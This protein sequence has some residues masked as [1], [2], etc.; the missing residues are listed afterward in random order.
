LEPVKIK[1]SDDGKIIAEQIGNSIY[2]RFYNITGWDSD[3]TRRYMD[4]TSIMSADEFAG[5]CKRIVNAGRD[6]SVFMQ[7]PNIESW[8]YDGILF[9]RELS[10][11]WDPHPR[12][13]ITIN[14][15]TFVCYPGGG[16]GLDI[17]RYRLDIWNFHVPNYREGH[18]YVRIVYDDEME[19]MTDE[20]L[21]EASRIKIETLKSL[22][23]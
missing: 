8:D 13:D 11:Y 5:I 3:E 17:A 6:V 16:D 2:V 15:Y 20:E 22:L 23:E 9:T 14:E 4:I 19:T 18:V 21:L 10:P 1:E 12:S 7:K